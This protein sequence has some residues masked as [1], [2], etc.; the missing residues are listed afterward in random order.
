MG[1]LDGIR[2]L[3]FTWALA[4][5]FGSMILCDMGA[6]V[7]KVEP[8]GITEAERG[9]GPMV[10]GTN[11][12]FFSINRGK[13]SIEIDL[14]S[15]RGRDIVLSL[16]EHADVVTENFSPGTMARLGLGYDDIA[17]RNARII[18]ASTSGFGQTGP[19][20]QRGA[21]DV[22]VQAMSGLMSITGH[23][24]GEPARAGYSI[25]DMAGGMFTAIGVLGA[26]VE[27][28][29]SGRGQYIDVAMFDSQIA[30]LEGAVSRHLATG[31]VPGRIGTRHPL[32][33]PFQAL[34]TSDGYVVIA[35]VK[36]WTLF[37]A[38]I[39]RDELATDARF[40]T[41]ELRTRNHAELE[42]LLAAALRVGTTDQWI[43][44]L[45]DACLVAPMNTV[46]QAAIDPQT[47]AREMI[48]DLPTAAGGHMR[49]SSSPLKYSRTPV[50]LDRGADAPGGHTAAILRDVL[51]LDDAS[52]AT[53][54]AE[55]VIGTGDGASAKRGDAPVPF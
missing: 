53:L 40:A 28:E 43:A 52:I 4:G 7:W 17:E 45:R 50:A 21:V 44:T 23:P 11:T 12:Y 37:C 25:A 33:T 55:G 10:D 16:A 36:D 31:E 1:P 14:K 38:L 3:D 54:A 5:P 8:V 39:D 18:Y 26:L 24:E 13:Q 29:R 9:P 42:P 15:E 22:I 20:A 51:G 32:I 6:E 2:I 27:R 49:V 19:Y 46:P 35:G 48:V 41:N 34:P 30:L 47:L